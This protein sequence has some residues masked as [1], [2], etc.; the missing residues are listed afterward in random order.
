MNCSGT[1][2]KYG[3]YVAAVAVF[4]IAAYV[5]CSP[6][7]QGKVVGGGDNDTAA[8]VAHESIQYGNETGDVTW[9]NGAVFSGM[10][11]YQIGGGRY[12]SD[13]LLAP[14]NRIVSGTKDIAW[15]VFLYFICFFVLLRSFRVDK[16]LC[17]PGALAIGLSSYFLVIIAAGHMSKCWTLALT[18]VV[19]AGFKFIFDRRYVPGAI[20]VMIFVALGFSHHPQ[21]FYYYYMMMG[22]FW[23][24]ELFIHIKEK[25]IRDFAIATAVFVA[26]TGIGLGAKSS[27]IFANAEYITQTMRGGATDL[28]AEDSG[29][30]AS[31]E[32]GLDIEYA[33]QWS[34][35]IDET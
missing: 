16:W 25:R 4:L 1:L 33:T 26:A 29:G 6:V 31:G 24:A 21:M 7:L 23:V 17:I 34:Y 22:L 32:K 28:T 10:P 8:G 19:V 2:K 11:N 3:A 15:T 14:L 18:A 27:N 9:W 35:G 30:D 5:Y 13:R 12:E 20:L